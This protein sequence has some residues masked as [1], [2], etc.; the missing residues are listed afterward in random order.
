MGYNY[1]L[2]P[3]CQE[4]GP[5]QI[6]WLQKDDCQLIMYWKRSSPGKYYQRNNGKSREVRRARPGN[7]G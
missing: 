7:A 4:A 6:V 5:I 2:P 3:P 1:N